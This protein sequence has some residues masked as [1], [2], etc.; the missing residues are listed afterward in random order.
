M[1]VRA[2]ET[3]IRAGKSLAWVLLLGLFSCGQDRGIVGV[4]LPL[5]GVATHQLERE[6][7]LALLVRLLLWFRRPWIW[8]LVLLL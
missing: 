8:M 1:V 7:R 3:W 2:T 5:Q 4:L 6:G